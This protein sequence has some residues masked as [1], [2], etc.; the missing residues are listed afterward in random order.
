MCARLYLPSKSGQQC[1]KTQ[2]IAY[3]LAIMTILCD[4]NFHNY[5]S[6]W[7][8]NKILFD[9]IFVC[10]NIIN[11][12]RLGAMPLRRYSKNKHEGEAIV[13]IYR[14]N[15]TEFISRGDDNNIACAYAVRRFSDDASHETSE[16]AQRYGVHT[17][18]Y[19]FRTVLFPSDSEKHNWRNGLYIRYRARVHSVQHGRIFPRVRP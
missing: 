3:N 2:I 18:G 1:R 5:F 9:I 10:A 11:V 6:L 19:T 8:R 15:S 4:N 13:R 16:T 17:Y 12:K 7:P 14:K